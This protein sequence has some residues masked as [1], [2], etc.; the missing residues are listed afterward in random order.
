VLWKLLKLF[1][2]GLA[3][4]LR[5]EVGAFHIFKD[6]SMLAVETYVFKQSS[7]TL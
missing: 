3:Y 2:T 7:T 6:P 4:I 5:K 1:T